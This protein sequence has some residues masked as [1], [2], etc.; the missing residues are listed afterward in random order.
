[1]TLHWVIQNNFKNESGMVKLVEILTRFQIPFTEVKVVPFVGEIQ[2]DLDITGNVICFG[3]YSMRHTAKS[4]GWFPGVFDL[5]EKSGDIYK[6]SWAEHTLNRD[7][8]FCEFKDVGRM[9]SRLHW[10]E[11]F[12]RPVSDSKVFAGN[13]FAIDEYN[14][15]RM[16][17][18]VLEEDDGSS[19]RANTQVMIS[20]PSKIYS[21]YRL[22][23]IG[24]KVITASQYKLGHKVIYS[25]HVDQDILD[26]GQMLV[27]QEDFAPAYSLDL[28]RTQYGIKIVEVN[29]IN[30]SGFYDA[31]VAKIVE[32]FETLYG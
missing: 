29:T 15:W 3:S 20:E 6:N 18:V 16:K 19:L 13:V 28:C 2:P 10:D 32:T 24:G 12:M 9:A 14:D 26:F 27:D 22:F 17:V 11:F 21:E 31:D 7:A 5:G 25:S 8:I 23:V 30:S 4:K 1:M